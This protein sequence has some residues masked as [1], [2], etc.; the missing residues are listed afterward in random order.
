MANR[1][2]KET[3]IIHININGITNKR[4]ELIHYLNEHNP[5]F[6][7]INESKIRKQHTIRIPNYHVIRKD[8]E[9]P[10]RGVGGGVA[11]LIRKDIK[12]NQLDTSE[13]DEEFLAISFESD[14]SKIASAT[15]YNPLGTSPSVENFKFILNKY[16]DSIFMGDYNSKHDFFGCKK[17]NK[18][19]DI[20]FN[21]L[22]ELN[23]IVTN[24]GTPTHYTNT[25]SDILDLCIVSRSIATKVDRC[26][27]GLDVGSD[28]MPVHLVINSSKI[29]RQN[30]RET[31]HH[32][33][34]DWVKF[35]KIINKNSTLT[36]A[37][38][39]A[40]IDETVNNIANIIKTAL[41][42]SCPKSKVKDMDFFI[43]E[44][45]SKLI[46]LKRKIKR[47]P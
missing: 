43:S 5:Q 3:E 1:D 34:T 2:Q 22:E 40:E 19:G 44:E 15:I 9:N 45:T 41:D 38:T 24:D 14:K 47:I 36:D 26:T 30:Q 35:R 23:L 17:Y 37:I 33:K 28:H 25:F 13:F 16:P 4:T 31:I 7:T 10:G 46:K 20:L 11:I 6:V 27:V 29:A 42:K 12:F 32:E 8:R 18:E 21:I 39:P